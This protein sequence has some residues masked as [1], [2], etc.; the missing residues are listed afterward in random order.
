MSQLDSK[1]RKLVYFA[2]IVV[3]SI[4]IIFLG[5]PSTGSVGS[6]GK[7]AQLRTEYDLGEATLGKVDPS[8]ATMNLVLLG[9]R[10][11][12]SSMLWRQ[13]IEQQENKDWAGMRATTESII[14]LQPHFLEVWRF[15]GWNLAFNVSA[16][17]DDV[18]DRYYW[19]KEGAKFYKQGTERNSKFPEL[20]W[21]TARVIGSKIGNADEKKYFRRYFK[22]DPDIEKFDGGADPELNPDGIDNYLVAQGWYTDAN[23]VEDEPG[24]DQHILMRMIFRSYPARSQFDYAQALQREGEFTEEG[25]AAWEKAYEM[26]TKEFGREIFI[27]PVG[28][29]RLEFTD[30]DLEELAEEDDVSVEQKQYWTNKYQENV[31]YRYWRLLASAES[32]EAARDAHRNIYDGKQRYR[33]QKFQQSEEDKEAGRGPETWG[34]LEFFELGMKQLDTLLRDY[35]ELANEVA[36]IEEAMLAVLYWRNIY[37]LRGEPI[38]ESFPLQQ[39]WDNNQGYLPEIQLQ[40]Q[41]ENTYTL[42]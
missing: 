35:P 9:M 21:D 36:A 28:G 39:I 34:A 15:Q 18:R 5:M 27:T 41:R 24:I 20:F 12:A 17:W 7:L 14:M 30:A 26:W 31:N 11:V 40:F 2:A 13:R 23:R 42:D 33:E 22:S 32:E 25:H 6:G 37:E 29:I 1:S 4:P 38:P 10:G 8:S 16:E 19:V 3:L